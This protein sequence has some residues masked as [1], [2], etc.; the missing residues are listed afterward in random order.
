MVNS[1]RLALKLLLQIQDNLLLVVDKLLLM[2]R[3]RL[4]LLNQIRLHRCLDE[5]STLRIFESIQGLIVCQ[6]EL[7][8][9]C[10]HDCHC[11]PAKRIFQQTSEFTVT[12]RHV[13]PQ[14]LL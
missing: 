9:T 11:V 1:L 3:V 7:T 8:H 5:F 14:V 2:I 4:W 6:V 12:I 13:A 10:Q